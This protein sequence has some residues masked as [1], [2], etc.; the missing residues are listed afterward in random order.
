MKKIILL[1]FLFSMNAFADWHAG[2]ALAIDG[3]T[4]K[5]DKAKFTNG[6]ETAINLGNYVLKMTIKKSTEDE[7]L[8][9]A[10]TVQEKKGEQLILVN[11]GDDLI[12][13]GRPMNE[14]YAKGQ[15]KQPNSIIT[16]K[17]KNI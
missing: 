7:G 17:L 4:W 12:E 2:V 11:K 13:I 5:T 3:E 14:I 10:Y 1:F 8:D 16:L 15:S 9:V 6:K